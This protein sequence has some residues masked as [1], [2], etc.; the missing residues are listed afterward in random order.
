MAEPIDIF[1]RRTFANDVGEIE[2]DPEVIEILERVL[3]D[4]KSGRLVS[5]CMTGMTEDGNIMTGWSS[6]MF[7]APFMFIGALDVIKSRLSHYLLHPE[8]DEE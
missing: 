6:S 8:E 3:E 1:T 2:A 7:D 5:F 4:A